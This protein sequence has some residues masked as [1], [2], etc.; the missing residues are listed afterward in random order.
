MCA[1][2]A[3]LWLGSCAEPRIPGGG[4]RDTTPPAILM[5]EPANESVN[6]RGQTIRLEFTEYVNHATFARAFSI[7]PEPADP[8]RF[9]WRKRRVDIRFKM[10]LR[11]STTYVI[12]LDTNLR[13]MRSVALKRPITMAFSTGDIIDQ[14]RLRGRVVESVLGAPVAGF[15]VFA[16]TVQ[17]DSVAEFAAY[18]T[19]T[20]DDGS[21]TLSYLREGPYF[22]AAVQDRNR[23][24][25]P[26]VTEP[27][28]APPVPVLT[29][30][31]DTTAAAMDWVVSKLDTIAPRLDR[32]RS[33]SNS[34]LQ[35]RFSE[36]V[37][38]QRIDPAAWALEDS[39][40]DL[41]VP[42]R[43]VY[44]VR[45]DNRSVYLR[46]AALQETLYRLQ[47]DSALADSS[48]NRV[49]N[50]A[51]YFTG[52]A[53]ADTASLRFVGFLPPDSASAAMMS[54][55]D[56]PRV[57]FSE[58]LL[59]NALA[60]V[61]AATD[62]SGAS[63][64]VYGTSRDGTTYALRFELPLTAEPPV[65]VAVAD[66]AGSGAIRSQSFAR[67]SADDQ[68]SLSGTAAPPDARTVVDL[69]SPDGRLLV[70]V[71]PDSMGA[72][73]FE[74]LPEGSYH[75]RAYLDVNGNSRWDG[76][77]LRPYVAPEPITWLGA[78]EN[79]RPRWD[80]A[81]ADTLRVPQR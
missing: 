77:Q 16:Y 76:G 65:D 25:Q 71:V 60:K 56:V 53:R 72:F 54:T 55:F 50:E 78:A 12:A 63:R 80:T 7:T 18:R 30:T 52:T 11:D 43:A 38:L 3:L 69:L 59:D 29:A 15:D 4:P 51:L 58:A 67:L 5:S 9:R 81:L 27:F 14:G 39:I 20:S 10:P 28:A 23:D 13:D 57:V 66:P 68:G 21:F 31:P 17:R 24:Q 40:S 33:L 6:F 34:R 49:L 61:V 19:Q 26:G 8:P 74:G 46:T 73:T 79:V 2:I 22:V 75:V 42:I 35:A 41:A 64:M 62:A 36:S 37:A 48:G 47:P 32:V 45:G 44:M 70:S 1:L